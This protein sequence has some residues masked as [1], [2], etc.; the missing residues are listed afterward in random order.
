[1]VRYFL[2]GLLQSNRRNCDLGSD[3]PG[4]E[5][6][7]QGFLAV[8]LSFPTVNTATITTWNDAAEQMRHPDRAL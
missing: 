7:L 6:L 2:K 3:R 1:M 5:F 4:F 8:S